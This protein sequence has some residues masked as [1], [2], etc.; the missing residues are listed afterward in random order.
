MLAHPK[1]QMSNQTKLRSRLRDLT[2]Q[3]VRDLSHHSIRLHGDGHV[4]RNAT[5]EGGYD[6][7]RDK[8]GSLVAQGG[9]EFRTEKGKKLF[10]KFSEF[11]FIINERAAA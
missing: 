3:E 10:L 7:E 5:I 11:S 6:G 2:R 8:W 1:N 9:V 4:L